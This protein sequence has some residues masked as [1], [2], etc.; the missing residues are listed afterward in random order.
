MS[1]MKVQI[2]LSKLVI[3]GLVLA[4]KVAKRNTGVTN[5][6]NHLP[7]TFKQGSGWV[8]LKNDTTILL[9]LEVKMAYRSMH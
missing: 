1:I 6:H 9:K 7:P 3:N 2:F 4:T 5:R 8:G